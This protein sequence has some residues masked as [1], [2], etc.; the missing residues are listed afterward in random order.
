MQGFL[1]LALV[2]V[3]RKPVHEVFVVS[4]CPHSVLHEGLQIKQL[5]GW[6]DFLDFAGARDFLHTEPHAQRTLLVVLFEVEAAQRP[7]ADRD[8]SVGLLELL[9]AELPVRDLA[10]PS[11]FF[12]TVPERLGAL[13]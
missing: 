10:R 2:Q 13:L 11:F 6:N 8:G 7:L 3:D 4:R 5:L 1:L 12:I 9:L